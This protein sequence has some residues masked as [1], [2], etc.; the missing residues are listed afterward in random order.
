MHRP[1]WISLSILVLSWSFR[2]WNNWASQYLHQIYVTLTIK[3]WLKNSKGEHAGIQ[4]TLEFTHS[5]FTPHKLCPGPS[6]VL[7]F[8]LLNFQTPTQLLFTQ[9]ES[10]SL[11]CW[12]STSY[13]IFCEKVW[14]NSLQQ[15]RSLRAGETPVCDTCCASVSLLMLAKTRESTLGHP[16][17]VLSSFCALPHEVFPLAK[18]QGSTEM[19]LVGVS[20]FGLLPVY[21]LAYS[22]RTDFFWMG[23]LLD[24]RLLKFPLYH[25]GISSPSRRARLT[26]ALMCVMKYNKAL[27]SCS[28]QDLLSAPCFINPMKFWFIQNY[29]QVVAW[30]LFCGCFIWMRKILSH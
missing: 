14:Q 8:R 24:N 26:L 23:K 1:L 3:C 29:I 22:F 13:F 6:S 27:T 18:S 30:I 25:F 5:V 2:K 9:D 21:L 15:P 16:G 4:D 11:Q 7:L 19:N 28:K 10:P 20:N 12:A 17:V